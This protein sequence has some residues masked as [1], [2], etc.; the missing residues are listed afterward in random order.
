MCADPNVTVLPLQ[1]NFRP[2]IKHPVNAIQYCTTHIVLFFFFKF[3]ENIYLTYMSFRY[4][5]IYTKILIIVY[6]CGIV[7]DAFAERGIS[8]SW[9]NQ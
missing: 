2:N 7:L 3:Y 4:L 1:N 5:Y 8:E 6:P 9:T